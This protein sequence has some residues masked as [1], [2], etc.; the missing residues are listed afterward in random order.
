MAIDVEFVEPET[1]PSSTDAVNFR[2]RA[3]TFVTF[4][5]SFVTKLI[6]FVTQLNNTEASINAKEASAVAASAAAISAANYKGVFVQG[7]SSAL[8]GESWS[9]DGVFYRCNVDTTDSPS[10]EPASWSVTSFEFLIHAATSKA[11][12]V[13][14]DEFGFWD[15]ESES[16][17]KINR[18]ELRADL[19]NDF[20]GFKNLIINANGL[21]N[22]RGYVSGTA[23]TIANQYTLDRW[24]VVESGQNLTF[25]TVAGVTTFTA[26]AGGVEQVIENLNMIGGSYV[27][28]FG[29]TAT[30]SVS[31]SSDNIT[32]STL[33]STDGIYTI[34]GGKY[35]KIKFSDGTFSLPQLEQNEIKTPFENRVYGLELSLCHRYYYQITGGLYS[36]ISIGMTCNSNK[37]W[38]VFSLPVPMRVMPSVQ[39][40]NIGAWYSSSGNFSTSATSLSVNSNLTIT[41]R[42]IGLE[43]GGMS[44]ISSQPL[45]ISFS[46]AGGYL[47]FSAEL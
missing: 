13:D 40:N 17:K 10:V 18:E 8:V 7:T 1:P 4:I 21:I 42:E 47:K 38:T 6:A 12:L 19:S 5:S 3:D 31:Q 35:I 43:F 30:V 14:A 27:L 20:T 29:G 39:Y 34:D 26:P 24:R 15:S 37:A 23:T 46:G 11:T 9:Y 33:T 44:G 32:Y 25:S 45:M 16:M 36:F 22:Q 2:T 28:S 41:T